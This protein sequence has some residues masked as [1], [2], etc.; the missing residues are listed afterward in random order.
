M[1]HAGQNGAL[2]PCGLAKLS[3]IFTCI[4]H[5]GRMHSMCLGVSAAGAGNVKVLLVGE[6]CE[7][8]GRDPLHD[9]K[10]MEMCRRGFEATLV[11]MWHSSSTA[12]AVQHVRRWA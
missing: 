8:E 11:R 4:A 2:G 5:E 1:I 9:E 6:P 10:L 3:E 7:K 12:S